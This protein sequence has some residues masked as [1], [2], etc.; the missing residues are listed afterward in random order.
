M[1]VLCY[2]GLIFDVS[3]SLKHLRPILFLPA[4]MFFY[5]VF[6]FFLEIL[7]YYFQ[8]F[9]ENIWFFSILNELG[10]KSRCSALDMGGKE[11]TL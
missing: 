1:S 10:E 11:E 2:S 9:P 5:Q 7:F 3:T 4:C 6:W 8:I